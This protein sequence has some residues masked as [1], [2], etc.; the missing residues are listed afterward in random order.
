MDKSDHWFFGG[1]K[2]LWITFFALILIGSAIRFYDL[3]DLPLDFNPTRQ[4]YSALKARGMYYSMMPENAALP[5]REIAIRQWHAIQEIEPPVI[6]WMSAF[7]YR[8]FGEHLWFARALSS[9]FWVIGAIPLFLLSRRISGYTGAIIG[10]AFYLFVPFGI[11]ASR[12]FQ[13]DPL[14]VSLILFAVW[15]VYEWETRRSWNWAFLSGAL[16]GAALFVKNVAVFPLFFAIIFLTFIGNPLARLKD[17]QYWSI[18][19]I[20]VLPSALYTLYGLLA[21]GFLGQQFAFRFFPNLL[22]DPTFYLR[23]KEQI[24]AT[25]GFG[26]LILSLSGIFLARE[27]GNRV[28][29]GLWLGYAFYSMTFAYH[30]ITHDYYQLML[31]PISSISLAPAIETLTSRINEGLK[32]KFSGISAR[33]FLGG[34]LLVAM[35][36]QIWNARVDMARNDF[37]PEAARWEAI[38]EKLVDAGSI[39]TVAED[40]GYRLAYWGWQDVEAWL[41]SGDLSLR[42]LDGRQIDMIQK[43]KEK[44][45]GKRYL[46][47]TQMNKLDKQPEIKEYIFNTYPILQSTN[48]L[49]IIDLGNQK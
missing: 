33:V 41:D 8:V 17:R 5:Q 28:L 43:F 26:V 35:A 1:K 22:V 34:T 21:A 12:S 42:E 11:I 47:I 48:D 10:A 31:I 7:L 32:G 19:G 45:T 3:T 14:M 27:N 39:L 24:D 30:T 36:I 6:E 9:L 16:I 20:A 40:Y 2:T 46:V 44:A 4:L 38:G 49:T 37:R 29:I 23:W 25:I 15:A 13:P 18:A